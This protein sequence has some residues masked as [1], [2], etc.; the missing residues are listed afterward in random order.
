MI[1]HGVIGIQT[2][3]Y[4][5]QL[6][7]SSWGFN[8]RGLVSTM[9]A[10][11]ARVIRPGLAT[12]FIGRD[13]LDA[14]NVSTAIERGTRQGQAQGAS[15]NFANVLGQCGDKIAMGNV[16]TTPLN[17]SVLVL[18]LNKWPLPG[19]IAIQQNG[20]IKKLHVSVL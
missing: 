16:E 11:S 9:N 15:F 2:N 1:H 12:N 6:A 13:I 20:A 8:N 7:G 5:G 3:S 14:A 4:A 19:A 17:N 10:L 18:P